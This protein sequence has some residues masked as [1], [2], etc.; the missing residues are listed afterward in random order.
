MTQPPHYIGAHREGV[1]KSFRVMSHLRASAILHFLFGN[2]AT[3]V[4]V[5]V[6]RNVTVRVSQLELTLYCTN[7]FEKASN[8]C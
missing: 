7:T 6:E 8:N 3:D 4:F 1:V 5:L 2:V